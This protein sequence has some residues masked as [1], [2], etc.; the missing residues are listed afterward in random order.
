[1]KSQRRQ[2]C[3]ARSTAIQD[4]L[5]A[6]LGRPPRSGTGTSYAV[7]R[8][9]TPLHLSCLL[10]TTCGLAGSLNKICQ[11]N[12]RKKRELFPEFR[13]AFRSKL[14]LHSERPGLWASGTFEGWRASGQL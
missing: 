6:A 9:H 11:K 14:Q 4:F 12:L 13:P 3:T 10:S 1:M 7:P 8:Q 2:H 5:S